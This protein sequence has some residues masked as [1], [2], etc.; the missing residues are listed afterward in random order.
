MV[1][2][3][4]TLSLP[5]QLFSS[6]LRSMSYVVDSYQSHMLI[7]ICFLLYYDAPF[8]F[9]NIV[10]FVHPKGSQ[11]SIKHTGSLF[12]IAVPPFIRLQC[13][14]FRSPKRFTAT[15]PLRYLLSALLTLE[16]ANEVPVL[17]TSNTSRSPGVRPDVH[18][19]VSPCVQLGMNYPRQQRGSRTPQAHTSRGFYL[20]VVRRV[21]RALVDGACWRP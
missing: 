4:R 7:S 13:S 17:E 3:C 16:L 10:R 9:Y 21:V 8:G 2:V 20:W 18:P 15:N 5:V 1:S 12:P 11:S 14:S 19:G 6:R